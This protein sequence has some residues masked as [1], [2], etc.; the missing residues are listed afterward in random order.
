MK[1]FY[2]LLA[3]LFVWTSTPLPA[4]AGC[5]ICTRGS[6]CGQYCRYGGSDTGAKRKGCRK[7]GCKIGGTAS[8]PTGSN[9]RICSGLGF[10]I[11]DRKRFAAIDDLLARARP[12]PAPQSSP[13]R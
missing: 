9:I 12:V 11:D 10:R 2:I 7:A 3:A 4:E 8:C 6:S 1:R 13:V 5:Y